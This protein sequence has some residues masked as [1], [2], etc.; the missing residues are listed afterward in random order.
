MESNFKKYYR[1]PEADLKIRGQGAF[2]E[3]EIEEIKENF[4]QYVTANYDQQR[5][6][7][8]GLE[9]ELGE[10]INEK[11]EFVFLELI[12]YFESLGVGPVS[13]NE[14]FLTARDLNKS[15]AGENSRDSGVSVTN[16]ALENPKLRQLV[17]LKALAH[18]L[19]HST[20]MASFTIRET[21]TIGGGV[22]YDAKDDPLLFEEGMAS[23]FEESMTPKIKKLFS[24]EISNEYDDIVQEALDNIEEPELSDE[25]DIHLFQAE[26]IMTFS[27]SEY[28]GS[29]RVVKYLITEIEN[30]LVLVENARIKR[31]TL[32]LAR[33]IEDR[34]GKGSYRRL[35]TAPTS[36]ADQ[37][38]SE[39]KNISSNIVP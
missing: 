8:L 15:I 35:T 5:L 34:F 20:A 14:I 38:L 26:D 28:S 24:E 33:A 27:S 37:V 39:L 6:S 9:K 3:A 32:P 10:E 7:S 30:F 23:L 4:R 21:I 18:E 19:Y 12:K 31:H 16:P 13:C 29:R 2:T 17:F 1:S 22:S 36:D 11:I 25:Y